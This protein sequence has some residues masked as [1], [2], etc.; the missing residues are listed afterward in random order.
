M[1]HKSIKEFIQKHT[2]QSFK[3]QQND[4]IVICTTRSINNPE[5]T[6][7]ALK[8]DRNFTAQPLIIVD[9]E[10]TGLPRDNATDPKFHS[11]INKK[12]FL[13]EQKHT[14]ANNP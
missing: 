11:A 1:L 8:M 13:N 5:E 2:I 12:I 7:E 4:L 10:T 14:Y 3:A 9:L 6:I